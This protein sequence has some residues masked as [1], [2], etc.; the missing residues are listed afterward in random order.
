MKLCIRKTAALL[1]ALMLLLGL[2][3]AGWAMAAG[4]VDK[5]AL[6]TAIETRVRDDVYT[7]ASYSVYLKALE[8]AQEILASAEAG[9]DDV[10]AAAAALRTAIDGLAFRDF[11]TVLGRVAPQTVNSPGKA[12]LGTSWISFDQTVDLSQEDLNQIYLFFTVTLT[13]DP[14]SEETGMFTGGRIA[15][16]SPDEPNENNAYTSLASQNLHLGENVI[17]FPLTEMSGQ[18]GTMNWSRVQRFRIYIDSLN[19][20]EGAMTMTL[21]EVQLIRTTEPRKVKVACVG[22]SITAGAING[23]INYGSYVSR[24]QTKLGSRYIIKNFGNSGKTLL[25]ESANG[26]GYTKT[27]TYRNSL[28][29][30]PDIVTIMLG[31][32]DSKTENWSKLSDRF[33][34]ELRALVQTYRDLPSHPLVILATSPTAHST[35]HGIIDGTV[36]G[37]IA[38]IQRKVAADMDCPVIEV[39]E[40]TKDQSKLFFDGI[41]PNDEG[42]L[43][44][45][46]VF[47]DGINRAVTTIYRFELEG[48]EGTIDTA[49]G[50]IEVTLPDGTDVTKLTPAVTL[51]PGATVTPDGAA[52]FSKP[53]PYTV[54]APDQRTTGTYIV[55]VNGVESADKSALETAVNDQVETKRYTALSVQEYLRIRDTAQIVLANPNATQAA[56]D[57]A[58][59]D[60]NEAKKNL[61]M[62][63]DVN[64]NGEVTAEDALMALQAVTRKITLDDRQAQAASVDGEG[65]ITASDALL[66]LQ[67]ATKKIASFS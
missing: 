55:T 62:L 61:I 45:A 29:F 53:V 66:I 54:T 17:Y 14:H 65:E 64:L 25:E 1:S 46:G 52:D 43:Y 32:N 28:A 5:D 10:D 3:P 36:S 19:R 26:N 51:A 13:R 11:G 15:L 34:P 35:A 7:S 44:L 30:E 31:T 49:G 21:S 37:E 27:D 12:V 38:P 16:R 57:E 8:T 18:T 39:N 33:E 23:D 60:L 58:L 24:L 20:F 56:V 47:T 6:Q 22:D 2:V 67:Y 41:H 50:R 9:Q 48:I 42:C 4:E 40:A 63:G 59:K